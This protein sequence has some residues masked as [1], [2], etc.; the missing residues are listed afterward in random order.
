MVYFY[1]LNISCGTV[2]WT[3]RGGGVTVIV[4]H[5]QRSPTSSTRARPTNAS[6]C[7]ARHRNLRQKKK[8]SYINIVINNAAAVVHIL[9]ITTTVTFLVSPANR[10]LKN[11]I[12]NLLFFCDDRFER[13]NNIITPR[14][15]IIIILRAVYLN[16]DLD[17]YNFYANTDKKI[18][19]FEFLFFITST[20]PHVSTRFNVYTTYG[21]VK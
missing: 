21:I 8:I 17:E 2:N 1:Y 10:L 18:N 7:P 13:N 6:F 9:T 16:D 14:A 11:N 15:T 4:N 20:N 12:I 19:F 5:S 3:G